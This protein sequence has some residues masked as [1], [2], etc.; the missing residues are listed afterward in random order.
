M[1]SRFLILVLIPSGQKPTEAGLLKAI[2]RLDAR[3]PYANGV[4]MGR[5]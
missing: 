3:L 5:P 2:S 1:E 4:A